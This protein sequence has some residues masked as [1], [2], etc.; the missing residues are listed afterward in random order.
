MTR[1]VFENPEV[2][3]ET[4]THIPMGRAG[5]AEDVGGTAIYL[6]SR[7]GAYV[8][9]PSRVAV[10][11]RRWFGSL[12]GWAQGETGAGSTGF[13]RWVRSAKRPLRIG[14]ILLPIAIFFLWNTPTVS[15]VIAL[16]ALCL[17]LLLVIELFARAPSETAGHV[18][19]TTP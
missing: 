19:T 13:A 12:V 18:P 10:A 17:F 16:V 4:L 2:E 5:T 11:I 8:T 3:A 7:A 1:V 6:S 15:L 9:G 14:A